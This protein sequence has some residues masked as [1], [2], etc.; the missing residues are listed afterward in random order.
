MIRL[1]SYLHDA[2]HDGEGPDAT[3]V[4][5]ATEEVLA[6]TRTD[7]LDLGGA[8]DHAREVGGPTLRAMSFAQ[9]GEL[10][11]AMSRALHAHREALLDLSMQNNGATRGDAKFDVDG[12]TGTL[13]GRF[14]LK[15]LDGAQTIVQ[16]VP[17]ELVDRTFPAV[18]AAPV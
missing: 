2:W 13:L 17:T 11:K 14:Q 18:R 16:L 5:P 15:G 1:Q 7:G 3:L 12:A 10:L 9:R 8:L 6:L 4:D